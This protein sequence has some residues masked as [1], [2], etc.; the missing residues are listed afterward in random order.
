[1]VGRDPWSLP[2]TQQQQTEQKN[3]AIHDDRLDADWHRAMVMYMRNN[4]YLNQFYW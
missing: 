4:G 1:M 3:R 2:L